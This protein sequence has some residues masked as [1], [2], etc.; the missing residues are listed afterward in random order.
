M[1]AAEDQDEGKDCEVTTKME[2]EGE[3]WLYVT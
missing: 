1:A 2:L 3:S